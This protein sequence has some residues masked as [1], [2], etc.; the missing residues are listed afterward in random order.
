MHREGKVSYIAYYAV[1]VTNDNSQPFLL[2]SLY[3]TTFSLLL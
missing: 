1:S 2:L 3:F